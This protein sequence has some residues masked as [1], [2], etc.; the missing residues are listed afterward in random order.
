MHAGYF[1]GILQLRN[2]NL[3]IL[4]YVEGEIASKK[5]HLA[6]TAKVKGGKDYY[7]GD[8]KFLL[9][10]GKRL[11]EK[12]TGQLVTTST[13]FSKNKLTG[14]EIHRMTVLFRYI[15]FQI[16]DILEYRGRD[17]ELKRYGSKV[18]VKDVKTGKRELIN[19][20]EFVDRAREK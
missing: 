11:K 7:L 17:V 10:L 5:I 6:K 14:K 20:D 16:G 8:N 13:L 4:D 1:E 12:Y 9:K 3:E 18:E 19:Y 2:A 15:P